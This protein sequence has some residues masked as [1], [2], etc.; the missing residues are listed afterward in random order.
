MKNNFIFLNLVKYFRC[1]VYKK[2]VT[3]DV[4]VDFLNLLGNYNNEIIN[5]AFKKIN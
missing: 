5:L 2:K 3:E 1:Y 4:F